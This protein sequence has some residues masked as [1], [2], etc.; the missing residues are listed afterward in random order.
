MASLQG[1]WYIA[2]QRPCA[3]EFSIEGAEVWTVVVV[4]CLKDVESVQSFCHEGWGSGLVGWPE[5]EEEAA[6]FTAGIREFKPDHLRAWSTSGPNGITQNHWNKSRGWRVW[7]QKNSYPKGLKEQKRRQAGTQAQGTH[8]GR[9]RQPWT[10]TA[11]VS[12]S[13]TWTENPTEGPSQGR[14]K[15]RR[16]GGP[17]KVRKEGK[18]IS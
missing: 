2:A 5:L 9:Q 4:G 3:Y 16:R 10:T 14:I 18:C 1:R 11:K 7:T 6:N 13:T 12:G 15:H 17:Q 8:Q